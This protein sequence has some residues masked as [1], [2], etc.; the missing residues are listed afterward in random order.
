MCWTFKK[1]ST[2]SCSTQSSSF[3]L[4]QWNTMLFSAKSFIHLLLLSGQMHSLWSSSSFL[5]LHLMESLREFSHKWISSKPTSDLC[6]PMSCYWASKAHQWRS[7]HPMLQSTAGGRRSCEGHTRTPDGSTRTVLVGIH[8]QW[9]VA[10]RKV[11]R[12]RTWLPNRM[13]G[14][15]TPKPI[16]CLVII[17]NQL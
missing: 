2:H 12:K 4:P 10:R 9:T 5:F 14:C 7:F 15:W 3:P 17:I 16:C 13:L 8:L 6:C 1:N 11:T